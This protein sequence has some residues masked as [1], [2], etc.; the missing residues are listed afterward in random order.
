MFYGYI[1]TS[2]DLQMWQNNVM[3][4]RLLHKKHSFIVDKWVVG[5]FTDNACF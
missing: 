4:L 5:Y 3:K 2:T 1:R